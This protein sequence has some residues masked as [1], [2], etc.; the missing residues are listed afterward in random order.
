VENARLGG[1]KVKRHRWA[2]RKDEREEK[3][4]VTTGG[5]LTRLTEGKET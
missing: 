1:G 3:K 4:R 5:M 2:G